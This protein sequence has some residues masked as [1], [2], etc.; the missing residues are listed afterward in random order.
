MTWI[1]SQIGAREHYAIPRALHQA[2]VLGTLTTDFWVSPGSAL[3][4]LP[5]GTRLRDRFHPDLSGASVFAPNF[6]MLAFEAKRR[7]RPA[8]PWDTIIARNTRYQQLALRHLSNLYDTPGTKDELAQLIDGAQ[9]N[10]QQRTKNE[11]PTPTLFSY[12]YA[13][14]DLFLFAKQRGWKTVL[15]QIDPGPEEERL[16]A[17]EHKRYAHLKSSWKPAPTAYWDNWRRE[18]ELAD[19]I[20]VNSEWSR[21]CLHQEGVPIEKMEII[22]LVYSGSAT[23]ATS[24]NSQ[25]A[26][27]SGERRTRDYEQ[28]TD[29]R[30]LF[31]GQINLRKGIGRLLDAMR[32]LNSEPITLT[33]AGSTEIDPSAWADLPKVKWIGPV[34][35]SAVSQAYRAADVFI[36]PTLSDGYALTQLEALSR[37]LPV[38]ASNFCGS[39]VIHGENGWILD[40]LEPRTLANAIL[41]ASRHPIQPEINSPR[42]T[43]QDLAATF[44]DV[45]TRATEPDA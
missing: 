1:V 42:F 18:I 28:R 21:Q 17:A 7:L 15:G 36:L 13:A 24:A 10:Q 39:A 32:L 29:L 5:V 31:L 2:G 14:H 40:D 34:P 38:I 37:G 35:R 12:S 26:Q 43:L 3:S 20:V 22:P 30:I 27:S 9:R 45:R 41:C 19:R 11:E 16:V 44:D 25:R 4:R 6:R 8:T 23:S 33:L